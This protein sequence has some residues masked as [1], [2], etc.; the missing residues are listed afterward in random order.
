M[1]QQLQALVE[2]SCTAAWQTANLR[3]VS[4]YAARFAFNSCRLLLFADL[5]ALRWAPLNLCLLG[6]I[7]C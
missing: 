4:W 6:D 3:V 5:H 2:F 7:D 1:Q